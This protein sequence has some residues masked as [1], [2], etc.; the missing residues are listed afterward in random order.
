MP[1][2]RNHQVFCSHM[3]ANDEKKSPDVHFIQCKE[4]QLKEKDET[5]SSISNKSGLHKQEECLK[6]WDTAQ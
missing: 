4:K 3:S 2:F 1:A 6:L 5:H